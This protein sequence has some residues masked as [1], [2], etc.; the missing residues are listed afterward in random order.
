LDF[1]SQYF[2]SDNGA[3]GE[4]S[5]AFGEETRA[6]GAYTL[7]SG[8]ES[9]ATGKYSSS[10]GYGTS[11]INRGSFTVGLWNEAISLDTILEVGIGT[12]ELDKKNAFE[13][14]STGKIIAPGLLNSL[15]DTPKSLIT[16]D[17]LD[18]RLDIPLA[19]IEQHANIEVTDIQHNDYLSW[20]ANNNKWVN[21]KTKEYSLEN[22]SDVFLA[23]LLDVGDVLVWNGNYWMPEKKTN[24]VSI[25]EYAHIASEEQSKFIIE[26]VVFSDNNCFVFSNGIRARKSEYDVTTTFGTTYVI[27]NDPKNE[28]DLIEITVFNS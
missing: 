21:I 4:N 22:M 17:Y 23:D 13:V 7:V 11:S 20:D 15:I 8:K 3:L 26:N 2:E 12:S 24:E 27:F 19:P 18:Y 10:I 5:V 14:Y 1:S 6:Y 9:K 28:G 16:K 25:E